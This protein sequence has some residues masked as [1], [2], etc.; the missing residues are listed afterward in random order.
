MFFSKKSRRLFMLPSSDYFWMTILPILP[1]PNRGAPRHRALSLPVFSPIIGNLGNGQT[2][3]QYC[4]SIRIYWQSWLFKFNC[5]YCQCPTATATAT[6]TAR[7]LDRSTARPTAA[8]PGMNRYAD[9]IGHR[10]VC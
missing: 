1:K 10:S 9:Q 7:P 8:L 4:Q 5:Q 6:A 3:C 2:D